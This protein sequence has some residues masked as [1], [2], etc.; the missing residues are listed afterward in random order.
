MRRHTLHAT[1]VAGFAVVLLAA[2][3]GYAGKGKPGGST[4]LS[5]SIVLNESAPRL[6]G[7]VTFTSS[8]PSNVKNPRVAVRC[9][10]DGTMGYAEAGSADQGFLLGGGMSDWL[11]HGG[12]ANCT[13]ELFY[14][15]WNGN[16]QQ[17]FHT[18]ATTAFWAAG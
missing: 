9:W 7:T 15:E 8:S 14:I 1:L 10:Y 2:A 16:N 4:A 5:A 18:L 3:P 11:M 13:A 12:P 17:V 6:G